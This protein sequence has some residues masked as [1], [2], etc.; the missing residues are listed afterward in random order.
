M[1]VVFG[2]TSPDFC[3]ACSILDTSSG[4]NFQNTLQDASGRTHTAVGY[5]LHAWCIPSDAAM[6]ADEANESN[7]WG[8][9]RSGWCSL[10][11]GSGRG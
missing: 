11:R 6:F 10:L 4:V 1:I 9:W 2:N 7:G 5:A 8:S 3:V